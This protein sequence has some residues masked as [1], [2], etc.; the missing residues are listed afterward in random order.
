MSRS[1]EFAGTTAVVT[2]G[3]SGIGKAMAKAFLTA[4]CHV[5]IADVDEH[6]L[7]AATEELGVLGIRT[8]VTNPDSVG[9]LADRALAEFGEVH[10]VCNNA[11][12]GPFGAVSSMTPA[13]WRWV[14]DINLHGV[15]HGVHAFL[16]LLQRNTDWGHVVNT[17]SLS[18]MLTPPN[19]SAYV[20]SKAAVLG[21]TEVLAAELR[22]ASSLVGVTALL[23]GA[24][25]TNIKHSLR[26]RPATGSSGL[27]EVDLSAGGRQ[28]RWLEA[29]EVG[30]MVLDAIRDDQLYL[31]THP[32]FAPHV[33]ER[34]QRIVGGVSRGRPW[35]FGV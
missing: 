14:L 26:S 21:L 13:D 7:A 23:P 28:L 32:E 20:A 8:D 3:A 19:T 29:D 5:I 12:V 30:S 10:V 22:A 18:V 1:V 25:R 34:Y 2:G 33:V 15:I 4:G 17:S 27:Y 24:V 9:S 11:G 6:A 35:R 16:P 31:V